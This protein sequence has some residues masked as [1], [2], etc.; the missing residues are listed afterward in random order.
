MNIRL[1]AIFMMVGFFLSSPGDSCPSPDSTDSDAQL[2]Y[3]VFFDDFSGALKGKWVLSLPQSPRINIYRGNPAPS[4]DISGDGTRNIGLLSKR[5]FSLAPGTIIRCDMYISPGNEKAWIGG[6]FGLPRNPSVF[7]KGEWPDWLVGMS[8]NYIGKL[9]WTKGPFHEEGTL[10]C[11][12]IDEDGKLEINR[13][14]YT[15]RYLDGWH[16]FEIMIGASG[17][18]EFRIDR[19]LIYYSR[20]RFSSTQ[21]HLPLLLGHRSGSQGKVYHDNVEVFTYR[22][23]LA[24]P[25]A[26]L[27]L[28]NKDVKK[29]RR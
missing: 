18:V 23:N 15:N 2:G 16:T 19:E 29:R 8:Y 11:Y 12:L 26:G 5:S 24:P 13:V 28:K 6:S 3:R 25:P 21:T 9:E 4:V 20:K 27:T 17:F 10:I 1:I 22:K 14:P 7:K